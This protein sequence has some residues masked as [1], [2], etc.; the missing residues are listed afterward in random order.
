MSAEEDYVV[1]FFS[2]VGI[3]AQKIPESNEKSPDFLIEYNGVKILVEL[4][5]KF[6][7]QSLIKRR[8]EAFKNDQIFEYVTVG[9]RQNSISSSIEKAYRQLSNRKQK[10]GADFCY[11]FLLAAGMYSHA[12]FEKIEATLYGLK[13][14]ITTGF[15]Q[16]IIKKCYYYTFNEFYRFKDILDGA[17]VVGGGSVFLYLND[18]SLQYPAT[19]NSLFVK[20]F[21]PAV[22]DPQQ[23][24]AE[25]LAYVITENIDR[26]NEDKLKDH[27]KE[28]YQ[29]ANVIT[30]DWPYFAATSKLLI[31]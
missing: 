28:K 11:I 18:R 16:P 22:I 6:D 25:N 7:N 19:K 23:E 10:V 29:L 1:E 3:N 14:I 8:K 17:F 12:Q 20:R 15:D 2:R 31:E 9:Q 13:H 4:K 26:K 5:T 27:L 30:F 24:E 21:L